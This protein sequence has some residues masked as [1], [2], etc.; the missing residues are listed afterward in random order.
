MVT[1][2]N[3]GFVGDAGGIRSEGHIVAARLN[4]ARSLTLLLSENVAEDAT[5]FGLEIFASR[6]KFVKNAARHEQCCGYFRRG[7]AEFLSGSRAVIFVETDVLNPRI[8]LEVENAF[9]G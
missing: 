1:R 6:P 2:D 9:G 4:H 8:A 3:P 7:M 5:L